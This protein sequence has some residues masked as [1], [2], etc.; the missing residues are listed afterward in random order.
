[1]RK[2]RQFFLFLITLP[3]VVLAKPFVIG[4]LIGQ[5]GNQLFI[6][7][8]ATSLALDNGAEA[9]FP[10]LVGTTDPVFNIPL[11]YEKVFF[12][13][14]TAKPAQDIEY[15]FRENGFHYTPIP[16][17]PNMYLF[18]FFQSEKY[19]VNH[20]NEILQL[21]APSQEIVT[22]LESK[23]TDI[24]YHPKT[25]SVHVRSYLKEDPQQ[26]FYP[27]YGSEYFEKAMMP[28]PEDTLFVVFSNQ[29]EWCKKNFAHIKRNIRYIEGESHYH[30]F[31]LMSMCKHNI[32]CNST[33]S[34]WAAYLNSNPDKL[35]IVPPVWF[36]PTCHHDTRDLIPEGWL[37]LN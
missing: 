19:F 21:F 2:I 28:F 32:I 35:V 18:G 15:Y 31:Y 17:K 14:N 7:A 27:T 1:M 12:H 24:I 22:Y 34:W 36:G 30:D 11:N 37:I 9:I 4:E 3:N 33:F 29:I 6:I 5:F 23:Y 16:Y 20:K 25:V 13:L 10:D 8:A 26:K